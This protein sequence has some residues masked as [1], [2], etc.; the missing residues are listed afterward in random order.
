MREIIT[1][2]PQEENLEEGERKQLMDDEVREAF[3]LL[4][5]AL[6]NAEKRMRES[7]ALALTEGDYEE[8]NR[9]AARAKDIGDFRKK[10]E[11][12][13]NEWQELLAGPPKKTRRH[14]LPPDQRTP[15]E[16][17]FEPILEELV[18]RGGRAKTRE[19][20]GGVHKRMRSMLKPGDSEPIPSNS[21]CLRWTSTAQ[22]ARYRL[23]KEGLLVDGSP[24]GVWEITERGR[25]WLQQRK[26]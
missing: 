3:A 20:L 19:V 23:V 15:L 22:S 12:L 13:T 25:E 7:A 11:G 18:A 10:M 1:K 4:A 26:G 9:L 24:R 8:A 6:D 2:A 17:F 14:R 21:R 16:E 5:E